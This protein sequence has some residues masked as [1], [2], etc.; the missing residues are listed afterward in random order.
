MSQGDWPSTT[1]PTLCFS[2]PFG[3][4]Q[5][6]WIPRAPARSNSVPT[7]S[8]SAVVQPYPV[9]GVEGAIAPHIVSPAAFA[10]NN[11]VQCRP[12]DLQGLGPPAADGALWALTRPLTASHDAFCRAFCLFFYYSS[13]SFSVSLSVKQLLRG[14]CSSDAWSPSPRSPPPD[15]TQEMLRRSRQSGRAA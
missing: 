2:P 13:H 10:V 1:R 12:S 15:L 9:C 14:T 6:E 7:A 11:R 3:N 4:D 8:Q 5:R